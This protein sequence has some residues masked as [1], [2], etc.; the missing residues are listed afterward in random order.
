MHPDLRIIE[1]QLFAIGDTR[2]RVVMDRYDEFKTT[3]D[4]VVILKPLQWF[5][6]Y[7]ALIR[8]RQV[9]NLVELGIFEGGSALLFGLLFD[10]LR[11]VSVDIRP[12]DQP[13]LDHLAR[14]GLADR[15]KLYYGVSQDDRQTL[16]AMLAAEFGTDPV[17]MVV[18]DASHQYG[19]S[20]ASFEILFPQLRQGGVYVIEDWA[21]AHWD[22]IFQNDLWLDA[23]ALSN[24]VF[25]LTMLAGGRPDLIDRLDIRRGTVTAIKSA[26]YPLAEFQLDSAYLM[27]GR[28][29][30]KI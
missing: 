30:Q 25:E 24:L 9:M 27:R 5:E 21:W 19:L 8:E 4:E 17:D 28:Q 10:E 7:A 14:L 22:G 29:L 26:P 11:V 13:V 3:P 15:V 16:G 2:F 20:R 18:D 23:P 12:P 1:P 6:Y